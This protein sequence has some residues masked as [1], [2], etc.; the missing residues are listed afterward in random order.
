MFQGIHKKFDTCIS[1]HAAR[2]VPKS[3]LHAIYT[4][5]SEKNHPNGEVGYR[6]PGENAENHMHVA[7]RWK[8]RVEP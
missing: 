2:E 1:A 4:L 5:I 8:E 3:P 6:T 7:H